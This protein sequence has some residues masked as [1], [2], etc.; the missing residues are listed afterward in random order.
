MTITLFELKW[1]KRL[2]CDLHVSVTHLILL[3]RDNQP[4]IYIAANPIFHER[5]KHIEIECHFVWDAFQDGFITPSY[6]PSDL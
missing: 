5:T 1:L 2:L 6:I 3:H 4:A